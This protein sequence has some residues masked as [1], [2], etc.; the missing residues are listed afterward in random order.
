M[1]RPPRDVPVI[2][3]G[4]QTTCSGSGESG[5]TVHSHGILI[6]TYE[7]RPGLG[8]HQILDGRSTGF[9]HRHRGGTL[10][11]AV[12]EPTIPVLDQS[13]LTSQGI[14]TSQLLPGAG[15]VDA[16]GS[17]TG[18]AGTAHLSALLTREQCAAA[19]LD[20][21]DPA[22]A[23]EW[24]IGLYAGA[25]RQDEWLAQSWPPTDCGSSGLGVARELKAR[26]L[27]A[28]YV[29][30]TDADAIADLLQRQAVMYGT[31][32]YNAWFEP[33]GRSALLDDIPNWQSSGIDGGHEICG[34]ELESVVQ[35]HAGRVVPEQTVVRFRNSWGRS[36]GDEGCFRLR[37]ST[38]ITL[39][40]HVTAVQFRLAA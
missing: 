23:E 31:P 30:A 28:S 21:T 32:W 34:V 9:F 37:L 20:V 19:G 35:D 4:H 11:T 18:N 13:H 1:I 27:V 40:R 3:R 25:T 22:A 33:H 5:P 38:Y 16:L 17:C 12:W 29:H 10:H 15:D 36:W 24:A 8:R 7:P 2:D 6:H 26:G 14:R 39:R